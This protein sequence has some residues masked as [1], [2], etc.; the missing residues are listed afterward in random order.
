MKGGYGCDVMPL[1]V[2]GFDVFVTL[3]PCR[4]V[5]KSGQRL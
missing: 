5:G 2:D 3:R 4:V 1:C